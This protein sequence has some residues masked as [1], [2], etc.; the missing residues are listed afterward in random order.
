M[1][2]KLNASKVEAVGF[3]DKPR[4]A[5][6][7]MDRPVQLLLDPPYD[8]AK[9]DVFF[10]LISANNIIVREK[11]PISSEFDLREYR[12][13]KGRNRYVLT[14]M[15]ETFSLDLDWHLKKVHLSM[16][17]RALE[18]LVQNSPLIMID[19][20]VD[21]VRPLYVRY[22]RYPYSDSVSL[23]IDVGALYGFAEGAKLETAEYA[24]L[25]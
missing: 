6:R 18:K 14:A 1:I 24:T 9:T 3:G 21:L 17:V 23:G 19:G 5:P 2:E 16:A 10:N 22:H 11:H 4:A 20:M 7:H 25:T 15:S 13:E 12:D 8:W